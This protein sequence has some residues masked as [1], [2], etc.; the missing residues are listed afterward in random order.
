MSPAPEAQ[1]EPHTPFLRCSASQFLPSTQ[2]HW[3]VH[4]AAQA[5][6]TERTC[7]QTLKCSVNGQCSEAAAALASLFG[8]SNSSSS[9][10]GG[11][12]PASAAAA[13]AAAAALIPDTTPPTIVILGTGQLFT[14]GGSSGTGMITSVYV[15]TAYVDAGATAYDVRTSTPGVQIDITRNIRT[16]VSSTPGWRL[17]NS[18]HAPHRPESCEA[19][20]RAWCGSVVPCAQVQTPNGRVDTSRPTPPG[21][22]III[23]YDAQ[24][25]AVPPNQAPQVRRRVQVSAVRSALTHVPSLPWAAL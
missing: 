8:S 12:A 16:R 21:Q 3:A 22:P 18:I 20:E 17:C 19:V 4:L 13:A 14:T 6:A 25:D 10:S 9:S 24:D 1:A 23:T 15:G 11:A 7:P 2:V 5:S